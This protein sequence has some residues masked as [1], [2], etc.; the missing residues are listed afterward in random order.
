MI[1]KFDEVETTDEAVKE[2]VEEV[3]ESTDEG[4]KAEEVEA[5]E[6]KVE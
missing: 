3:V 6:E 1:Y 4:C 5:P 2:L